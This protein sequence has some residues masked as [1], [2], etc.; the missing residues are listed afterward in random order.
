MTEEFANFKK[1]LEN[2]SHKLRLC[3]K[4]TEKIG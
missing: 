3:D 2:L 4:K 1:R